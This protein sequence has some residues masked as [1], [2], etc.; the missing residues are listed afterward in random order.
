[1]TPGVGR[2]TLGGIHA[3]SNTTVGIRKGVSQAGDARRTN[4]RGLL[5]KGHLVLKTLA[6]EKNQTR[7][8][9]G[10][11]LTEREHSP[12]LGEDG[13]WRW[14][15]GK[16]A[17]AGNECRCP[18]GAPGD[19]LFI[20]EECWAWGLWYRD[21]KTK[22]GRPK[23]RFL[24]AE[25]RVRYEKPKTTA[26]RDGVEGWVYRHARYM[27]RWA[28]RVTV[29]VVEIRVERLQSITEEDAR[30]EGVSDGRI[31]ADEDG[32][33]RIGYVLGIDDGKC[34]LYPTARRAFEV[35]WDSI[36]GE[37]APWASNPF[38]WC[39]SFRRLPA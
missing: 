9:V 1:M 26:K 18:Y 11:E 6:G 2:S 38:V 28:S 25:R 33:V 22:T 23:F 34:L 27:P 8:I 5:M 35:G 17:H 7:R 21:G 15:T 39:V 10:L 29:E 4:E 30:A 14:M 12:F 31:P 3:P 32:P 16:V 13:I 24:Q 19:R 36:N 37:R 20:R